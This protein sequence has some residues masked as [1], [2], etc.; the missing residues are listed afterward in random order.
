MYV[1]DRSIYDAM[2]PTGFSREVVTRCPVQ[3]FCIFFPV[4]VGLHPVFSV[5]IEKAFV[6]SSRSTCLR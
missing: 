5:I 3:Y 6:V 1:M 4:D 2:R